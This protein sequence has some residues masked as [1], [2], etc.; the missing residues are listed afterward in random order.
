MLKKIGQ[1]LSYLLRI[2]HNKKYTHPKDVVIV[3][4]L[5][6]LERSNNYQ[7]AYVALFQ[8]FNISNLWWTKQFADKL[9]SIL[10]DTIIDIEATNSLVAGKTY[11]PA[12]IQQVNFSSNALSSRPNVTEGFAKHT[13]PV[14]TKIG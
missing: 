4:Y 3:T 12:I 1:R 5:Y 13:L 8:I 6:V 11:M 14:L 10:K 9:Y 2:E 7:L